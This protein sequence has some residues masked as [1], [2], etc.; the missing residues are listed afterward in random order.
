MKA[1][2]AKKDL[3]RT[4]KHILMF[5][6][7]CCF[8]WTIYSLVPYLWSID[9]KEKL[10]ETWKF[11]IMRWETYNKAIKEL[12]S[13]MDGF[14]YSDTEYLQLDKEIEITEDDKIKVFAY[15]PDYHMDLKLTISWDITFLLESM[16]RKE[17][18]I[19]DYPHYNPVTSEKGNA[20]YIFRSWQYLTTSV[21]IS[22]IDN[23]D[24]CKIIWLPMQFTDNRILYFHFHSWKWINWTVMFN[25]LDKDGQM[26]Y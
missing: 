10:D 4:W 12:E 19:F 17:C 13:R 6:G 11:V 26:L 18:K 14:K 24:N 2:L 21:T 7:L 25:E 23:P 16:W 5:I 15:K 8:W 9:V 3:K 20:C 22:E 1:W